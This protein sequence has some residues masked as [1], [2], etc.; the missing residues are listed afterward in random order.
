M[1]TKTIQANLN[2]PSTFPYV[3]GVEE[4]NLEDYI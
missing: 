3:I 2:L 4:K 1:E